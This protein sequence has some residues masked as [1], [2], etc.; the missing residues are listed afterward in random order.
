MSL[1]STVGGIQHDIGRKLGEV[2]ANNAD[3]YLDWI[4]EGMDDLAGRFPRA[5]WLETSAVLSLAAASRKYQTSSIDADI[6]HVHDIG[7]SAETV[8]LKYLDK[9]TFDALDPKPDDSGIPTVYTIYNDEIEFYP[10]PNAA[11]GAQVNYTVG[12]TT[13]S[14]ASAVPAIPRRFLKSLSLYGWLQGLY[15]REDFNEAQVVEAKYEA[16]VQKIKRSLKEKTLES[17]RMLS[18]REIQKGNRVYG[19]EITRA[20]F[21]N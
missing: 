14:A 1:I 3:K 6:L 15:V 21:S 2:S 8:K 17:K 20:F 11:V 19:D 4:N 16:E 7:I 5:P 13:V 12:S 10:V 9:D 18:I